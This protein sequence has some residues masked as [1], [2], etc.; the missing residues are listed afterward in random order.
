MAHVGR[1]GQID[2]LDI[3]AAAS[4]WCGSR[5]NAVAN[6]ERSLDVFA[7]ARRAPFSTAG[8]RDERRGEGRRW[9]RHGRPR[10]RGLRCRAR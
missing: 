3:A 4:I 9:A 7:D 5:S 10:A 8:S 6:G 1:V 2:R